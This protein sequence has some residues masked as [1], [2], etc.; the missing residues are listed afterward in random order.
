MIIRANPSQKLALVTCDVLP[1]RHERGAKSN[2]FFVLCYHTVLKWLSLLIRDCRSSIKDEFISIYLWV[3]F[4]RLCSEWMNTCCLP[5]M[6]VCVCPHRTHT[7]VF[8]KCGL[9][10][11]A[12]GQSSQRYR[13]FIRE[14]ASDVTLFFI[15]TT[16]CKWNEERR[17]NFPALF[18]NFFN[19]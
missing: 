8:T 10:A 17:K 5:C 4:Y 2:F 3:F 13:L 16:I 12:K 14:G 6:C 1:W 7:G 9:E 18:K 19:P 11:F 15:N